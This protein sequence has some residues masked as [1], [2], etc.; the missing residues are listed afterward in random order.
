[1]LCQ[2]LIYRNIIQMPNFCQIFCEKTKNI[3]I[4]VLVLWIVCGLTPAAEGISTKLRG[5][6]ALGVILSGVAYT[7]HALIKHDRQATEKLRHRL[8]LPERVVHFERGFDLWRIEYYAEQ[9]YLFRNSRFIK[10]VSCISLQSEL[11][12]IVQSEN[13]CTPTGRC[14]LKPH[15]PRGRGNYGFHYRRW[16]FAPPS[17]KLQ[18]G[19]RYAFIRPSSRG[20]GNKSE[21]FAKRS[22]AKRESQ[23]FKKPFLS[24]MPV[25]RYPKWSRL[26]LL[27]SLRVPQLVSSDLDQLATERSL[28]PRW[29]LSH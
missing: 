17:V 23:T 16:A 1:M 5:K 10:T 21:T 22:G 6:I 14:G 26:Y 8:G 25:L 15:L 20:P 2:V 28:D 3:S 9:C 12:N 29:S 24:D 7:T 13:I 18:A 19:F 11:S 4:F 27:D